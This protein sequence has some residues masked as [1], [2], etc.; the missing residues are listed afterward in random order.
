M[1]N[2]VCSG[3]LDIVPIATVER[4]SGSTRVEVHYHLPSSQT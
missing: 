4:N 3:D 1:I 2:A